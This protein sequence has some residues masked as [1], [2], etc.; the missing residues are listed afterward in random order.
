MMDLEIKYTNLLKRALSESQGQFRARLRPEDYRDFV[1]SRLVLRAD[2]EEKF[3]YL[4][5]YCQ[6]L[7]KAI[8][9]VLTKIL[10]EELILE[11]GSI[12]CV[13]P[14]GVEFWLKL[15]RKGFVVKVE[16]GDDLSEQTSDLALIVVANATVFLADKRGSANSGEM[17]PAFDDQKSVCEKLDCN[18]EQFIRKVA[19]SW[20]MN[21][22]NQTSKE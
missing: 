15:R 11:E 21:A 18:I 7:L 16:M 6:P 12:K 3:R 20:S 22:N 17:L 19:M 10:G 14:P 9:D 1:N 13:L 8:A 2:L 5:G 4:V